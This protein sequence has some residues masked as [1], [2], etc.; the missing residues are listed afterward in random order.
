MAKTVTGPLIMCGDLNIVHASPA[1]R[2]LD[3][4]TDL[5]EKY[6]VDNTLVGLKFNGKVACD[7]ILIN[8]ALTESNFTV[9]DIIISDH[10]PLVAELILPK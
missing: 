4:L 1:M 6:H 7:H 8:D 3:F 5:T 9:P 10:K 2:E